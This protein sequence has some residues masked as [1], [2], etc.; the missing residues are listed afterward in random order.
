M[1][2]D[3]LKHLKEETRETATRLN[4]LNHFMATNA[5][6]KLPREDKDLLYAQQRTM[7]K[8]VQILGKRIERAGE[9]FTHKD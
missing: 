8:Y 4:K 3:Q 1:Q 7:S 5:F 9:T 6:P 2:L